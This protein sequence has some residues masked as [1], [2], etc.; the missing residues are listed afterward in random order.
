M[1]PLDLNGFKI[2]KLAVL[3]LSDLKK[4]YNSKRG[5]KINFRLWTCLCECGKIVLLTP[6][7]LRCGH[8]KSCGCSLL[9]YRSIN[10]RKEKGYAAKTQ[11]FLSYQIGAKERNL[12][13]ELSREYFIEITQK[14]CFYCGSPPNNISKRNSGDFIYNGIDRIDNNLGYS[15][16]NIVSCCKNCNRAKLEM[17]ID[18]FLSF[19]KKVYKYSI[20]NE[21]DK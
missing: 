11:I 15:I 16:N 4:E 8:I 19:I 7:Q 9:E 13:W 10:A 12:S 2:G 5:G 18:D 20:L 21:R 3:Y 1:R 17:S 6:S 14:N